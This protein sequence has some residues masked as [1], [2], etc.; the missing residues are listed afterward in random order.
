MRKVVKDVFNLFDFSLEHVV[1][2]SGCLVVDEVDDVCALG[3]HMEVLQ[4]L[5][6]VFYRANVLKRH[7][8]NSVIDVFDRLHLLLEILRVVIAPLRNLEVQNV[9]VEVL[10]LLEIALELRFKL[11]KTGRPL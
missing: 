10:N 1:D 11:I 9:V 3:K 5:Y 7:H 2:L 8:D 6:R 4:H